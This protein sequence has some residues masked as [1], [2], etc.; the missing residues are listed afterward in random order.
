MDILIII[1][2]IVAGILLFLV[3]IFVIPGISIAGIF[4][5]LCLT[6]A[7]Y[8]AFANISASAGFVTLAASAIACIGTLILF[9]KSK[10]L[11]KMALTKDISSTIDHEAEKS[12]KVGDTGITV[13][14]L[15]LIGMADVNGHNVEVRSIDGFIDERTP[16]IV[17]RII[18]GSILVEKHNKVNY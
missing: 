18:D 12:V 3:E 5:F 2:L 11:D 13:T 6:Y 4:A 1:G 10:T 7:N 9:M 14:R 15:A 17:T 8:Y 16:I